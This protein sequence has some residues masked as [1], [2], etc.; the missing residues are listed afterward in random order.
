MRLVYSSTTSCYVINSISELTTGIVRI[1]F[2][3]IQCSPGRAVRPASSMLWL[4]TRTDWPSSRKTDNVR[5]KFHVMN[6]QA[7]CTGTRRGGRR[8]QPRMSHSSRG[9][10]MSF[11]HTH[12]HC[13]RPLWPH[14]FVVEDA[15][16]LHVDDH[17][18]HGLEMNNWDSKYVNFFLGNWKGEHWRVR[19]KWFI[20]E[21]RNLKKCII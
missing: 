19:N 17:W 13:P 11:K 5:H 10:H 6:P 7:L 18:V 4:N 3:S 2:R 21:L 1:Q 20:S 16:N 15:N 12:T 9:Q 8:G 14:S